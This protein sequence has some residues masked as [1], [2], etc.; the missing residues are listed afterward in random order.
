MEFKNQLWPERKPPALLLADYGVQK[1]SLPIPAAMKSD[2][3]I[4]AG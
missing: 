4:S 1:F 2:E 3:Q